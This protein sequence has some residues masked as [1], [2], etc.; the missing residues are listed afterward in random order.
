MLKKKSIITEEKFEDLWKGAR[1]LF[2]GGIGIAFILL[3][4]YLNVDLDPVFTAIVSL[5]VNAIA[6]TSYRF[7]K[8]ESLKKTL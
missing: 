3:L 4:R 5:G 2:W 1:I 6:F 7:F 8:K